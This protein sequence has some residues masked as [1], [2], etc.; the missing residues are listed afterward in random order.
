MVG[1]QCGWAA[2]WQASS[3]TGLR[4]GSTAGLHKSGLSCQGAGRLAG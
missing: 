4:Y 3:L 2:M 1:L